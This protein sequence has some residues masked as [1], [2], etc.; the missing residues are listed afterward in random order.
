LRALARAIVFALL[1]IAAVAAPPAA[2]RGKTKKKYTPDTL[3]HFAEFCRRFIVL[4][5]GQ[6]FELEPFQRLILKGFFAGVTEIL[7]LLPKKN[8]KT[9]LLSALAI[10]HLIYTPDAA[11]YIAAS[12][13]DQAKIMYDQACGFV[14]RKDPTT[15]KLLPQ[16]AALQRAVLLRKGSREIRSR[17]DSGFIWVLSGDKDTADGVIPTLALVDELHRHKDNGQLYGVLHDGLSPRNGRIMVISTPGERLKSA[18]GRLRAHA[19]KFPGRR[20][21]GKYTYVQSPNGKFE[22]HEWGLDP[23]DDREDLELVKQANPLENNTIEKLAERKNSPSMTPSRWARFGCGVWMQ[24]EDAAI[25]ALDWAKCGKDG[26][27]IAATRAIYLALDVGWRWDTTA[28]VPGEP[29]G[30]EDVEIDVKGVKKKGWRFKRVRYGKPKILIPPRDGTSLRRKDI[31]DAILWYRDAGYEIL[32]VI[33]DRN[34]EGESI[35][36]ELEDEHGLEVIEHSQDPSPMADAA[37]G[38]A[39][40][41]GAGDIEHPNDD[42]FTAHVLAAKAKTTTGEKWRLVAPEQNRGARKQG[43]QDSDDVEYVDAA[44]A[45]AM[46]H[47]VATAPHEYPPDRSAYRM[48]FA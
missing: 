27:R 38:F 1:P 13:R 32:G 5:N 30:R 47:H 43:Q 37:M 29:R 7:V 46:L 10:Y 6:P 2:A 23:K 41:I 17:R 4:D 15:G 36:Q 28:V 33:F 8:G 9:T 35:A 20:R 19:Y 22:M 18:L 11:C 24:G 3:E 26:L 44:I 34:A 25:S 21:T 12:A 48:E 42:E 39:E 31:I 45:A 14:E 40:S 16:A